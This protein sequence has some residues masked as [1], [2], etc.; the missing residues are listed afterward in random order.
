M[1]QVPLSALNPTFAVQ[2]LNAIGSST[3]GVADQDYIDAA[4]TVIANA[5]IATGG[6]V[7]L[8]TLNSVIT[9]LSTAGLGS[10]PVQNGVTVTCTTATIPVG[11]YP[12][13]TV[14]YAGNSWI[15]ME[16]PMMLPLPSLT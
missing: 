6:T 15:D 7:T 10:I 13:V 8:G 5:T 9:A 1:L 2:L 4:Q 12:A 11:Q 14:S 16:A 3:P